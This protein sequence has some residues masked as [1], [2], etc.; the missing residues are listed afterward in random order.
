M[1]VRVILVLAF[2][3]ASIA[4]TPLA[5]QVV[6]T[7]DTPGTAVPDLTTVTD[8]IEFAC[9]YEIVTVQVYLDLTHTYIGDMEID[10]ESPEGTTVL[11]HDNA[12]GGAENILLT[13]SDAGVP[14]GSVS[15][16]CDCL[17]EPFEPLAAYEGQ[18][19]L[20]TWTLTIADIVGGDSGVLNEWCIE[21]SGTPPAAADDCD[22][23]LVPDACQIASPP[24]LGKLIGSK[25]VD[26]G[27]MGTGVAVLGEVALVG[28]PLDSATDPSP[29]EA[30]VYRRAATGEWTEE[31]RLFASDGADGDEFGSAVALVG[32][33]AFIGAPLSN[34]EGTNSGAVYV[35]RF[36]ATAGEW[37][38]EQMLTAV[39]TAAGDEFG[40]SLAA[41]GSVALIGAHLDDDL[42]S[43]TGSVYAFRLDGDEW[44]EEQKLGASDAATLDDFG[45][46]VA[47]RGCLA[48]A[49][50]RRNDDDGA[51]SGAAYILQYDEDAG[52][53]SEL[54]KLTASDGGA[55]DEF[56]RTVATDGTRVLVGAQFE[57]TGAGNAGAVYAYRF[58]DASDGWLEQKLGMPDP[59][60]AAEFGNAIAIDA[61]FAAIG[62]HNASEDRGGV[63]LFQLDGSDWAYVTVLRPAGLSEDDNFGAAVAI[64]LPLVAVGA[65]GDDEAYSGAGAAHVFSLSD[66]NGNATPDACDI[67][68]GTSD[69]ADGN[70]IPDECQSVVTCKILGGG[71]GGVTFLRG[72]CDGSGSVSALLDALFLLVWQFSGG[73]APPCMDAADA[74]GSNG[75]TALLDALFLLSWQFTG[76][77]APPSPGTTACG[78]DNDGDTTLDCADTSSNCE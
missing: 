2:V 21:V 49:G 71:G 67:D 73:P 78:E 59:E 62:A 15:F 74:D 26:D 55:S 17:M 64:G 50:A 23:D 61:N 51:N 60:V 18:S 44:V 14:N 8:D 39:D 9:G 43:N 41:D 13:Y 1:R 45:Y 40:F 31:Q 24:W 29:G 46:S 12:G 20:G 32:D 70:G 27:A 77:P 6:T 54:E 19:S 47:V 4:S 58:D 3:T 10:L 66:C 33:F 53:W 69:D 37:V 52:E 22:G 72:D 35:F 63:F 76:G 68:G 36:D 57:D 38:E 48:V 5:A 16:V 56:G 34:A 30:Y 75:V 7:C 28:S 65:I 25:V 42:A 11:L